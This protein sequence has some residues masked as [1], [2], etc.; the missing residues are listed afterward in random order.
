[1][2]KFVMMQDIIC[3]GYVYVLLKL[4]MYHSLCVIKYLSGIMHQVSKIVC[5]LYAKYHMYHNL[6]VT[7]FR[8]TSR[9]W[10]MWQWFT[11]GMSFT[12]CS[13]YNILNISVKY[14]ISHEYAYG[15]V[16]LCFVVVMWFWIVSCDCFTHS[17][18]G[19]FTGK[20][21]DMCLPQCEWSKHNRTQ[22]AV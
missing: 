9:K 16:L 1:M 4:C 14:S 18:Q 13:L 22:N 7:Y 10:H 17:L 8:W 3:N 15:F 11:T 21:A 6:G 20:G 19:Y 12:F 2:H 5:I